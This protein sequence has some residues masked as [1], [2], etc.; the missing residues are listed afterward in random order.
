MLKNGGNVVLNIFNKIVEPCFYSYDNILTEVNE[1]FLNFTEYT[2]DELLGKSLIEIGLL[3]KINSQIF[4]DNISSKYS[5]YIFTKSLNALEINISLLH[6]TEINEKIFTFIEKPNSRLDDKLIFVKQTFIKNTSGVAVYSVPDLILLKTNEKYLDLVD[7]PFNTLKTSIGKP[8][9]DIISGFVGSQ[10]EVIWDTILISQE[11]NYMKEFEFNKFA[12]GITYWDSSQVPIF[13]NGKMKYILETAVEVTERVFENKSLEN[14]NKIIEHQTKQLEDQNTQLVSIIENLS[15]G[16]ILVDSKGEFIMVNTEA[17]KLVYQSDKEIALVDALKKTNAFDMEGNKVPYE[18]FPSVRALKGEIV[19]NVKMLVKNPDA[20]YFLATSSIPIYNAFGDLTMIVSFFHDITETIKQ[21]RK[22]EENQKELEAIIEHIADGISIIDNKGQYTLFNKSAREM[23]FP[24]Y[25]D[26]NEIG[27][28]YNPSEFYYINGDKIGPE[29]IPAS[30]V[31]RGEQFKNMRMAINLPYKTSEIVVSGTPIYDN[32]GKFTLGVLS[33]RDMTDYF[34]HEES[35]RSRFEILDRIINTFDLPVVRLSC[36][37]LTIVDI[38]KKAF[39]IIRLLRPNVK[40]ISQIKDTNIEDLFSKIKKRE[41]YQCI[42][43]VLK[44]KK[45]KHLNKRN[46][47]INGNQVYWNVI[48]EPVLEVNG[49]IGEILVLIIDVTPEIKSNIDMETA[50]KLQGEFL[51][52]ISHEL[53]TPLNVIFSTAQLFNMYCTNGSL[54]ENKDSIV[55]Y[56]DSIKQNSYR[57][58]KMINNIVDLSKIEAGFFK[59]NLL[60][61]NIVTFVEEIVMSVTIFT[62]SKGLNITFDTNI[63]EKIIACDPEKIER[64]VLNLI[65]NAI[66]FTDEGDEILV[67]VNDK[68]DFV[69]ISVKDNGIGIEYK[70]LNM[71]FD[72]FKQVDRSLSRNAEGTG[73]GLSLVKSIV[74]LHCGSVSVESEIGNGSEFI[75][76]LPAKKVL[77][78]SVMYN[79]EVRSGDQNIRVELSDVY[80]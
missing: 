43:E 63:E 58:S 39:G 72:R 53:K 16:V 18:N 65:S 9:R 67:T 4:L 32:Q 64:V 12:R 13:E 61:L 27:D 74:E 21:S 36:P 14:Q 56:I 17:K 69:E 66:K 5:G 49:E 60:N 31:M 51:V 57:L 28:E 10:A 37:H 55:K 8:I 54:D 34:K 80:S 3:L 38:N 78:E 45:T 59:L 44:E 70:Y 15:E 11:T 71:I 41:Y 46:H 35:I 24:S 2:L 50:L 77:N 42:S 47:L 52:N 76:I 7:S 29:D 48:F 79:S 40:S 75:V 6:N 20:E 23:F 25:K 26:R 1:E 62:N 22:I 68:N 33:S 19:K 30:R 73:I